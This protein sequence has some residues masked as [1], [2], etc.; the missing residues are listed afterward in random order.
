MVRRPQQ[1]QGKKEVEE[2]FDIY[3]QRIDTDGNVLWQQGG[4][5][6][7]MSKG[8]GS[9]PHR[10]R[11][12]NDGSSVAIVCWED[13]RHLPRFSIYAQ[14]IDSKGNAQW[15]KGGV[16]VC[17]VETGQSLLYDVVSDGLGGAIIVWWNS[18]SKTFGKAG[19][20][21]A[22]TLDADGGLMWPD[23]GVPISTGVKFLT[24]FFFPP[25]NLLR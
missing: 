23:N 19:L 20:L 21:R 6:L 15:P 1:S 8:G 13:L 5:P 18:N 22:Q 24:C 11:V 4:K 7:S 16:R 9:H 17:S 25:K 3:A 12:V 14:R 2:L 10:P